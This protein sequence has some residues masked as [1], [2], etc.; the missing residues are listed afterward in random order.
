MSRTPPQSCPSGT[1]IRKV[2]ARESGAGGRGNT[3]KSTTLA[4]ATIL[5]AE[6]HQRGCQSHNL[7]PRAL[8]AASAA[9]VGSEIMRRSACATRAMSRPPSRLPPACGGGELDARLLQAEEEKR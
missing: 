7:T 8:A 1:R 4:E 5:A 2:K 6:R 3:R 9:F